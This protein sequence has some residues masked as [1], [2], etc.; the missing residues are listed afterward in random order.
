MWAADLDEQL[1]HLTELRELNLNGCTGVSH[2][3]LP[4]A[5]ALE[6]V[7]VSG[8]AALREAAIASPALCS[9][10]AAGCS[11]SVPHSFMGIRDFNP[12]FFA[13]SKWARCAFQAIPL[14]SLQ[15]SDQISKPSMSGSIF[16][17]LLQAYMSI[18]PCAYCSN[19]SCRSEAG[20]SSDQCTVPNCF[21]R[22]L[23]VMHTSPSHASCARRLRSH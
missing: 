16:S 20:R 18:L 1:P 15:G 7:D 21:C 17:K 6:A 14:A 11:R 8:C 10:S 22:N 5:L 12:R 4:A 13:R 3:L 9:L 2:L 19:S 23:L